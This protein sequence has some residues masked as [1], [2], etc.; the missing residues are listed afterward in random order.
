VEEAVELEGFLVKVE[1]VV[2]LLVVLEHLGVR[3]LGVGAEALLG[4]LAP[5]AN[6]CL[7]EGHIQLDQ[8]RR[9]NQRPDI[10]CRSAEYYLAVA[11]GTT[12]A[13]LR[14]IGDSNTGGHSMYLELPTVSSSN[15]F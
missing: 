3:S 15:N 10:Q 11:A 13:E 5:V 12:V 9:D 14:H 2:V 6:P 8:Q 4:E 7:V 1:V